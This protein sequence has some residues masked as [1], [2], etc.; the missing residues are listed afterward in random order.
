MVR[1]YNKQSNT[2]ILKLT[3]WTKKLCI[4]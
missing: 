1:T 3:I 2:V 4:V